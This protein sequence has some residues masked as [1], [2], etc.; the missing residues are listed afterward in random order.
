MVREICRD[1]GVLSTKSQPA[2][3]ADLAVAADLLETL[4]H[5]KDGCVGM[6]SQYDRHLQAN[7]RL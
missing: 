3:A 1:E 4:R 5:H 7:H 6:A 2:T